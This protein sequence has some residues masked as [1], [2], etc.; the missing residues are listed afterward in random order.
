MLLPDNSTGINVHAGICCQMFWLNSAAG[1][2]VK[3]LGIYLHQSAAISVTGLI[4]M[5]LT[6]N[7]ILSMIL[8]SVNQDHF[9]I[10]ACKI[11]AISGMAESHL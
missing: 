7:G 10:P 11:K 8:L 5:A 3:M 9:V 4:P 1:Q 2:F 6:G